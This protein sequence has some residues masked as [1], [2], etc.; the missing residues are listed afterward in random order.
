MSRYQFHDQWR[1][2]AVGDIEKWPEEV[3]SRVNLHQTYL[4]HRSCHLPTLKQYCVLKSA[5]AVDQW[6]C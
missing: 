1:N 6:L 2:G 4:W 5:L 3:R